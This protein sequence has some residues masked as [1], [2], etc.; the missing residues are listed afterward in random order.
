MNT[1]I[2]EMFTGYCKAHNQTQIITC[3]YSKNA[4]G[5]LSLEHV[6][7]DFLQCVHNKDCQVVRQALA[8]E[9]E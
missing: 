7:C 5:E 8:K 4:Y 3:E 1:I 2:E 6:D 9:D